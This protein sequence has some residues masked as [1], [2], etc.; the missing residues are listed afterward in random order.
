MALTFYTVLLE[1]GYPV[2]YCTPRD[3]RNVLSYGHVQTFTI[4]EVTCDD[5]GEASQEFR[6]WIGPEQECCY[7]EPA[8]FQAKVKA[9]HKMRRDTEKKLK[10][11]NA[12]VAR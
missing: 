10:A 11:W 7:L 12:A 1:P 6:A 4:K 9:L 5:P 8:A 2:K 3:P